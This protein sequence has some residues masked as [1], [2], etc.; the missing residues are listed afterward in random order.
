MRRILATI[1][2]FSVSTGFAQE[3]NYNGQWQPLG[4][5]SIPGSQD[6]GSAVG[7]GP[8][9]FIRVYG[10]EPGYMLTGSINGGL[11]YTDN[12]G[13][14]WHNAGSDDWDYST[15]CWADYHPD[16]RKTWFA[17]SNISGNNGKPGDIGKDGGIF[18]TTNGG[19]S[20]QRIGSY[21]DFNNNPYTAIYGTRFHP[22]DP[23]KMFAMTQDG[24]YLTNDCMS[25]IMRWTKVHNVE[26]WIYDMDFTAGKMFATNFLAGKWTIIS[27]PVLGSLDFKVVPFPADIDKKMRALTI[28]PIGEKLI[29]F[30][31]FENGADHMWEYDPETDEWRE[32]LTN[33]QITFGSGHTLAVNPHTKSEVYCGYNISTRMYHYP[34]M[35]NIKIGSGI[36]ADVEFIIYDPFDTNKIF[37][38]TH[39]GVYVTRDHGKT[40][41]DI[42]NGLGLAEV[43]GMDVSDIDPE[44]IAIGC[45]H[46]GS[47]VRADWD[48]N[49]NYYWLNVNGGD[50]LTALMDSKDP[51]VIYTSNQYVSGGLY[52]STDT[53]K[54]NKNIHHANGMK[55]SG[56]EMTAVLHP[57]NGEMLFFN[58]MHNKGASVG[59]IDAART[60]NAAEKNS[61]DTITDFLASHQLKSYKVYGLFNS[62][63]Y[64]NRLFAYV[65]HYDKD[66]SGNA[67]TRHRLFMNEDAAAA[68]EIVRTKWTELEIPMSAWL[69]DIECDPDYSNIIYLSYAAGKD[70]PETVVGDKGMIYALRYKTGTG[71]LKREIDISR[72]VPNSVA[73]RFNMLA[74]KRDRCTLLF[75]TRTGVYAGSGKVLKGRGRW[76]EFGSGMP[77]CKIFGLHYHEGQQI[78]TVGLMGRGV[79]RYSLAN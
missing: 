1:C 75:A 64:P 50:G 12:G 58:F 11:F 40:F 71:I 67:V 16:D 8:V 77:H 54:N 35:K 31:D 76:V 66:A 60:S 19:T 46:D 27:T 47:S 45:F 52:H 7:T 37:L 29:V 63:F 23:K 18:R 15:C 20:W 68:P 2:V 59:N 69:G 14:N 13:K 17:V 44:E 28:E 38:A 30:L 26:G 9:E 49:G 10:K 65:L 6:G 22:K 4:P 62:A 36:H 51:A 42:S 57:E 43:M 41:D 32:L 78:L 25:G 3:W 48:K 21:L 56:W 34:D 70:N 55:T 73:G 61:A 79:W 72:N 24:L 53:G 74:I 33:Q 5:D 39:G